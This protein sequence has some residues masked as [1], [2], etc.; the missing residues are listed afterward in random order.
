MTAPLQSR[1][2]PDQVGVLNWEETIFA[3]F[4]KSLEISLDTPLPLFAIASPTE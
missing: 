3:P 1:G 2:S 4:L